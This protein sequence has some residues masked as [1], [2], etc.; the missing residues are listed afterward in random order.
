[1]LS[2]GLSRLLPSERP[3]VRA[4]WVDQREQR[5]LVGDH[6]FVWNTWESDWRDQDYDAPVD[7]WDAADACRVYL[8]RLEEGC[9]E[10]PRV[11][12]GLL[13]GFA[14]YQANPPKF[15]ALT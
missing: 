8:S 4:L 5:F 6:W 14:K 11:I 10:T 3:Y 1:M 2:W 15:D 13:E 9:F 7:D 12:R